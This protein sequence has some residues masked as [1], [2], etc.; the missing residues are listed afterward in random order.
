MK[1][2]GHHPLLEI[3]GLRA[4]YRGRPVLNGIDLSVNAGERIA[5]IGPNGCGKSTLF[6]VVMGQVGFT[7]GEIALHGEGLNDFA[8]EKQVALGLGYLPQSDNVFPHLTVTENLEL[9]EFGG[10]GPG[11]GNASGV[12]RLLKD[13]PILEKHLRKRAGLLSGGERQALAIA[14]ILTRRVELLLLDEP[15]AGLSPNAGRD[16]MAK[17]DEIQ[18]REGFAMV[19]VEHRLRQIQPHVGRLL[20]MRL[21]KLVADTLEIDRMTDAEWLDEMYLFSSE[22]TEAR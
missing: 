19:I 22:R 6:K 11:T 5:L 10:G 2:D 7:S 1:I 12:Q 18:R 13:F 14:M 21:G 9:A 16:V 3:T 4:G 8:T 17:L 15:I 20:V